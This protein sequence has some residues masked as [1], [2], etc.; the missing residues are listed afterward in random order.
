[1]VWR[2]ESSREKSKEDRLGEVGYGKYVCPLSG[3]V[4][5]YSSKDSHH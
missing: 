3:P 4:A 2:E 1:M 5:T